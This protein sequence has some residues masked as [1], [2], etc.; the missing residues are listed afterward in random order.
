MESNAQQKLQFLHLIENLKV[1]SYNLLVYFRPLKEL[2]GSKKVLKGP[3]Q[4]AIT[5]IEWA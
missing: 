1:H 3:N 4:L 2:A 5:C